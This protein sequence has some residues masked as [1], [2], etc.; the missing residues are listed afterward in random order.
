MT[1]DLARGILSLEGRRALVTGASRGIGRAIATTFAAAGADVAIQFHRRDDL[2]REVVA[3]VE[4]AGRSGVALQADL[5]LAGAGADLARRCLETMPRI[6]ILVLNAAEQRRQKLPDVTPE[7]YSLQ[8]GTGF[9]GSYEL[10]QALLPAMQ[11]NRFGRII[12]IGSVQQIR[13]NAELTVYAAMKAALANLMRN[14]AKPSGPHGVTC[15]TILPGLI[16]TDRSAEV[17][18]DPSAYASLIERIPCRREGRVEEVAALALFLAGP[19]AGY[20]TGA[21]YLIDGG[22]G[23]P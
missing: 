2:A 23:L 16:E 15:N 22:L 12:A 7:N 3:D 10:V 9:G 8:V 17:R 20:M 13:P 18:V 19:A 5:S 21:E 4:K 6:D 14:L 1:A 11:A